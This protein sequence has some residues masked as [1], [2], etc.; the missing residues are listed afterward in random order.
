MFHDRL[1]QLNYFLPFF[2][3]A[4]KKGSAEIA[5]N[6]T[7]LDDEEL[8]E[9]LDKARSIPVRKLMLANGDHSKYYSSAK[10]YAE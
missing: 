7:P 3:W 8:Q 1:A 10:L 9:I 2:P 5:K 6:I 4:Q